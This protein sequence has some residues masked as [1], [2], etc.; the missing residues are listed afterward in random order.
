MILSVTVI[1]KSADKYLLETVPQLGFLSDGIDSKETAVH[2]ALRIIHTNLGLNIT[3]KELQFGGLTRMEIDGDS[4]ADA[5]TTT[6]LLE[7][8]ASNTPNQNGEKGLSWMDEGELS[9]RSEEMLPDQKL[10]FAELAT[11]G[12]F[13]I[14]IQFDPATSELSYSAAN[15]GTFN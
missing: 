15:L 4:N 11:R 8:N 7:L 12:H 3:E 13:F 14:N 1:V 10:A 5:L 6:F 2:A 9:L